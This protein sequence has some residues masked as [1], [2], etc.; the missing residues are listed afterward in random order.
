M[1]PY[2]EAY[3]NEVEKLEE[4]INQTFKAWEDGKL[5]R[6]AFAEELLSHAKTFHDYAENTEQVMD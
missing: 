4:D 6:P 2:E 5:S 1:N 3:P